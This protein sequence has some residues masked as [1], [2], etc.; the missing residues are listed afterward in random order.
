MLTQCSIENIS[1]HV[2]KSKISWYV[3]FWKKKK[4]L[5]EFSLVTRYYNWLSMTCCYWRQCSRAN[6]EI[7]YLIRILMVHIPSFFDFSYFKSCIFRWKWIKLKR[8]LLQSKYKVFVCFVRIHLSF[9]CEKWPMRHLLKTVIVHFFIVEL[10]IVVI[11][12]CFVCLMMYFVIACY[13]LIIFFMK[14]QCSRHIEREQ[15]RSDWWE[16]SIN[17]CWSHISWIL[18]NNIG[19]N[20]A[21]KNSWCKKSGATSCSN[22]KNNEIRRRCKND[23]SR[24]TIAICQSGRDFHSWTDTTRLDPHRK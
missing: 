17:R 12:M 5:K 1:I 13:L 15:R 18:A 6:I 11:W 10:K 20:K 19:W 16:F 9:V 24:S 7:F 22:K 21:Y 23:I 3:R 14:L 2:W 4:Y 8:K